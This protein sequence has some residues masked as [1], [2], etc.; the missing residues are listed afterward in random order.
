MDG[1]NNT[2]DGL[3]TVTRPGLSMTW[4]WVSFVIGVG[5]SA[6]LIAWMDVNISHRIRELEREFGDIKAERYNLGVHMGV[7]IRHLNEAVLAY[8]R[9]R[10]VAELARF[11]ELDEK[12]QDWL[13]AK[14]SEVQS[15]EG[16]RVFAEFRQAYGDY[17]ANSAPLT[18]PDS[19]RME[20][21]AFDTIYERVQQLSK[22][23]LE[24]SL[25]LIRLQRQEFNQ[26]MLQSQR[27]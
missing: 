7:Q 1:T 20:N 16:R 22:R 25:Q 14:E 3:G 15:P 2:S 27:T 5:L 6:F 8:H 10:D 11:R 21:E 13:D 9:Q 19:I 18:H 17:L 12:L 23:C 4:R 24:L 26:F